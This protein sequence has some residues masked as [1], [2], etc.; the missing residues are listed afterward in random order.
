M[1]WN[2]S[3]QKDSIV[4]TL[5]SMISSCIEELKEQSVYDIDYALGISDTSP[6]IWIY[7]HLLTHFVQ[8]AKYGM[9]IPSIRHWFSLFSLHSDYSNSL[10]RILLSSQYNIDC[11]S[12]VLLN[13]SSFPF[14]YFSFY[15]GNG[16]E[17]DTLRM[18]SSHAFFYSSFFNL[19]CVLIFGSSSNNHSIIMRLYSLSQIRRKDFHPFIT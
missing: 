10:L 9:T 15:G 6:Q 11:T 8:F 19:D 16:L 17:I 4:D 2:E 7:Y 12:L 14:Y 1:T 13:K 3:N 5:I 18:T